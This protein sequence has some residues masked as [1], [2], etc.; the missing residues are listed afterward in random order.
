MS[1]HRYLAHAVQPVKLGFLF[2]AFLHYSVQGNIRHLVHCDF[3]PS[4]ERPCVQFT[5]RVWYL[6]RKHAG[7]NSLAKS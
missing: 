6:R 4:S 2:V 1:V 7:E 3:S 5:L